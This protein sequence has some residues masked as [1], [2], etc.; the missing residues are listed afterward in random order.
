MNT[1]G[2]YLSLSIFSAFFCNSSFS[3]SSEPLKAPLSAKEAFSGFYVTGS[4][5]YS[6]LSVSSKGF[7]ALANT[8]VDGATSIALTQ[9][10]N[11]LFSRKLSFLAGAGYGFTF[12]N[13]VCLSL[14]IL[15][16]WDG[17]KA[18]SLTRMTDDRAD[19]D[20]SET[21]ERKF[22][23]GVRFKVG[24][25]IGN[26]L[27]PYVGMGVEQSAFSYAVDTNVADFEKK[28]KKLW[29]I[30]PLIGLRIRATERVS[31]DLGYSHTW[32]QTMRF[33]GSSRYLQVHRSLKPCV[34]IGQIG[35]TYKTN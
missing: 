24:Q 13:N 11:D 20:L 27:Y 19:F 26:N 34:S 6:G 3:D 14:E 30:S 1:K 9:Q 22:G 29:G 15:G 17:Q 25:V 32:Y 28:S 23:W 33:Q 31:I 16:F 4:V 5:G 21:L 8:D 2:L 35:F 18:K 10:K 12:D 7:S